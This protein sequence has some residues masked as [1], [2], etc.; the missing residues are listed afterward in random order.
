M[1]KIKK[2]SY[3]YIAGRRRQLMVTVAVMLALVLAIYF[4]AL[5]ILGTNQNWFTILAALIC[6]PTAQFAVR[7]IMF[8]KASGCS[9]GAHEEIAPAVRGIE[10]AGYDL[11][12]TTERE[13]Y[14]L[15][16]AAVAGGSVIAFTEDAGCDCNHAQAHIR[17]MMQGNGYHGY[18]VKVF[19]SLDSYLLRLGQLHELDA[20]ENAKDAEVLQLLMQI[21]L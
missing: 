13:N 8:I 12:M 1:H 17:H 16:H 5:A 10:T 6:L 4:G 21:S 2:G 19:S 11:Y 3:G 18:T 20:E 9:A 15:S 14:A 7:L